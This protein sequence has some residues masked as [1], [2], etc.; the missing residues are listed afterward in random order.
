MKEIEYCTC[1]KH[2]E[3]SKFLSV[4]DRFFNFQANYKAIDNENLNLAYKIKKI[5]EDLPNRIKN[6]C[7]LKNYT[8]VKVKI[9]FEVMSEDD[10]GEM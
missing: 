4:E 9:T 2:N 8:P 5:P 7:L 3:E 1:F 6:W 10:M